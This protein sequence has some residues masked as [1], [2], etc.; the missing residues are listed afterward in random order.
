MHQIHLE[1]EHVDV[2][3][4]SFCQCLSFRSR[5]QLL[6]SYLGAGWDAEMSNKHNMASTSGMTEEEAL[7]A[8]AEEASLG[9]NGWSF[10]II[11]D[12]GLTPCNYL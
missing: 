2:S 3:C 11:K 12:N 8:I 7:E 6:Q 4:C 5:L 9:Y 1:L 10:G